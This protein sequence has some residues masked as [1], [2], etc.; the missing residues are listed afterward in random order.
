MSQNRH[1]L[2]AGRQRP[3]RERE[4]AQRVVRPVRRS[5][6][7]HLGPQRL[8]QRHLAAALVRQRLRA[9]SR[10]QLLGFLG[11]TA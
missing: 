11:S 6:L 10:L 4:A 5:A 8:A 2:A 3:A 7:Q 1:L 9:P